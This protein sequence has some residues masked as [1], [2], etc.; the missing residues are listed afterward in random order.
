MFSMYLLLYN[1]MLQFIAIS[2][3]RNICVS[4]MGL[5][6]KKQSENLLETAKNAV[7]IAIEVSEKKAI[8][9]INSKSD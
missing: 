3:D 5:V 9:F 2:K 8:E 1:Y 7:E 6:L 4:K